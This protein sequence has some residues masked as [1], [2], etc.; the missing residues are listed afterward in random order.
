MYWPQCQT[1][2]TLSH[3]GTSFFGHRQT[4]WHGHEFAL[5][6]FSQ[7]QIVPFTSQPNVC[8][9]S[10]HTLEQRQITLADTKTHLKCSEYIFRPGRLWRIIQLIQRISFMTSSKAFEVRWLTQI[11]ISLVQPIWINKFKWT[12]ENE[13]FE[14]ELLLQWCYFWHAQKCTR[15]PRL[16]RVKRKLFGT[17]INNKLTSSRCECTAQTELNARKKIVKDV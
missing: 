4:A 3:S 1:S 9:I 17:V 11:Q 8:A 12:N 6:E 10:K 14:Y 5:Y 16:S 7:L 13:I 15:Y 2:L